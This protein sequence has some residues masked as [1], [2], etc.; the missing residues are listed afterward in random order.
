MTSDLFSGWGI[1][2]LS[3]RHPAFNP[4][5]YHLGTVWPASNSLIGFGLKRYGFDADFHRLAK[6]IF[7]A[8]QL[9][10]HD[11]LP[12]V[13][14]GHPRDP[15]HPHPG[16][17]PG[18]NSPQAWSAAAVVLLLNT[19][20]G[21]IPLAPRETLIIDPDLPEWLPELRLTNICIGPTRIGLR[22]YRDPSGVT[23]HQII[24]QQGRLRIYRSSAKPASGA[25]RIAQLVRE[26]VAG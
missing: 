18:A 26:A 17:Y 10:E 1:R 19:M 9:F 22:F 16:I 20:L 11:R 24:E 25:D 7:D 5:A 4:F 12:E 21:L 2:T 6:A 14:G 15:R 8:S 13:F 3:A 23:H